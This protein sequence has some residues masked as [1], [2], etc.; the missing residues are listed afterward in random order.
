MT[1]TDHSDIHSDIHSD[2]APDTTTVGIDRPRTVRIDTIVWGFILLGIAAFFFTLVQ[3]DL[4][5][6]N[7]GV[8]A[9]WVAIGI[10]SLVIVGGLV[11]ALVR[12][13]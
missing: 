6:F 1:M 3:F 7:P 12:R 13:R 11:G 4:S 5:R 8:I 9:A 10:G 2:D